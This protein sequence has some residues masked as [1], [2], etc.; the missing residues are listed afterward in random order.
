MGMTELMERFEAILDYWFGP[1]SGSKLWFGGDEATDRE[2]RE[3]FSKDLDDAVAGRLEDWE[4]H[5]E[6]AVAL[7]VLL[8]QF[9]LQLY[10]E[11]KKSYDQS[12]MAIPI[13][14]R[15]IERGFDKKVSFAKRA[16]LYMPYMHAENLVLQ[17]KGVELF[18]QLA[19]ECGPTDG[20]SAEGFLKF[21]KLHR[22]VIKKYGRFPGRNECYG[23]PSTPEEQKYLDEGGYF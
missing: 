2:V 5:P 14:D 21:A 1:K 15:A 9:S 4:S 17:E 8:D 12:A 18:S 22:D 11:Q 7:V 3:K 20:K 10:R 13:A 19:K 6:S 23:R 16:F